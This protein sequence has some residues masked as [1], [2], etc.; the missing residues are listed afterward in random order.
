MPVTDVS[1]KPLSRK[2][3]VFW[4]EGEDVEEMRKE[5]DSRLMKPLRKHD[6]HVTAKLPLLGS[7]IPGLLLL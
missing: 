1:R 5:P 6:W 4:A 2:L 3:T 7:G